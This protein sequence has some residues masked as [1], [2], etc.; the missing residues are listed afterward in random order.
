MGTRKPHNLKTS[1]RRF[2]KQVKE[3]ILDNDKAGEGNLENPDT[4]PLKRQKTQLPPGNKASPGS[5][6]G[7]SLALSSPTTDSSFVPVSKPPVKEAKLHKLRQTHEWVN[8]IDPN[9]VS[10]ILTSPAR[11]PEA[12]H[13][14]S[15]PRALEPLENLRR[16][17]TQDPGP[18]STINNLR[19]VIFKAS[20]YDD[21]PTETRLRPRKPPVIQQAK[22]SVQQAKPGDTKRK[23]SSSTSQFDDD[24]ESDIRSRRVSKRVATGEPTSPSDSGND[25]EDLGSESAISKSYIEENGSTSSFPGTTPTGLGD[26]LRSTPETSAGNGTPVSGL[27]VVQEP[28]ESRNVTAKAKLDSEDQFVATVER[29]GGIVDVPDSRVHKDAFKIINGVLSIPHGCQR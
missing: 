14:E 2:S 17:L 29:Q 22:P 1:G 6:I 11:E 8:V 12:G 9:H 15:S 4:P 7:A 10:P 28:L 26:G 16:S 20:M 24:D 25:S 21:T 18:L 13:G 23:R 27:D 5:N 3:E 19:T